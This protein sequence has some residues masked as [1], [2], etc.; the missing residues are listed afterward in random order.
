MPITSK[1]V[2]IATT[3]TAIHT[4]ASN[5]C[6][7]HIFSASGG[8][9][10]TLGPATVVAGTGYQLLSSSKTEVDVDVPPGETLYGITASS[11]KSIGVLVVEF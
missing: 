3:A 2:T 10:V 7:L 8:Q 6:R 4:A 1:N 5:G 11:T 9:D